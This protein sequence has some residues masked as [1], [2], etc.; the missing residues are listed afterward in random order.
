MIDS[1]V[2][3]Q[4]PVDP[5]DSQSFVLSAL[6]RVD[7][8]CFHLM[9]PLFALGLNS[10]WITSFCFF[11]QCMYGWAEG[12]RL[13]NALNISDAAIFMISTAF[14]ELKYRVV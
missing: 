8:L 12:C 9:P 7:M 10:F 5:L 3:V 13:P 4:C 6:F 1:L 14:S 2:N 11:G